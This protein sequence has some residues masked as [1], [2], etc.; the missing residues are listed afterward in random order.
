MVQRAHLIVEDS[1]GLYVSLVLDG[2]ECSADRDACSALCAQDYKLSA[3]VSDPVG[4]T[5]SS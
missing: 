4:A 2:P 5:D 1:S 3:D